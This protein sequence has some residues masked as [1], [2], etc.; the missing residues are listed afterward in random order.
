MPNVSPGIIL[1]EFDEVNCDEVS[2]Y[3][4]TIS[5][6]KLNFDIMPMKIFKLLIPHVIEPLTHVINLSLRKL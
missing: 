2:E 6:C 5:S 3:I 1:N 4:K